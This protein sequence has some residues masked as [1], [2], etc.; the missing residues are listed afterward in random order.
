MTSS[1]DSKVIL[2]CRACHHA[3]AFDAS[4][5]SP[6]NPW[7]C[8]NCN[9][10][11]DDIA[12]ALGVRLGGAGHTGNTGSF[13]AMEDDEDAFNADNPTAGF[14]PSHTERIA[15]VKRRPPPSA[16]LSGG[17]AADDDPWGNIPSQLSDA[18]SGGTD[19][20]NKPEFTEVIDIPKDFDPQAFLKLQQ[21]GNVG[22]NGTDALPV[23]TPGAP[24]A[25]GQ[26]R[27]FNPDAPPTNAPGNG[28]SGA[29]PPG[30]LPP[31]VQFRKLD[32]AELMRQ[33]Q[34][35]QAAAAAPA[36]PAPP[37]EASNKGAALGVGCLIAALVL[38]VI[39]AIAVTAYIVFVPVN[40]G[41]DAP[42]G[43]SSRATPTRTASVRPPLNDRLLAASTSSPSLALVALHLPDQPADGEVAL[44]TPER[45]WYDGRVLAEVLDHRVEPAA[46]PRPNSPWLPGLAARLEHNYRAV[47]DADPLDEALT[48]RWFIL[49]VGRDAPCSAAYETLYTAWERGARLQLASVNPNNPGTFL[50]TEIQPFNWPSPSIHGA[51]ANLPPRVATSGATTGRNHLS[52]SIHSEGF[53]LSVPGRS[54]PIELPR[55][56]RYPLRSLSQ[57]V[58]QHRELD[59][60]I[61]AIHIHARPDTPMY[62]LLRAIGAMTPALPGLPQIAEVRL[63]PP[64]A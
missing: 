40:G 17:A 61:E 8:S 29:P 35:K 59:R 38:A 49:L 45:L 18:R 3:Y 25:P 10:P 55:D 5:V 64:Y 22:P 31:T 28:A 23:I 48:A 41:D 44:I 52:L 62:T 46:H 27:T 26:A 60:T 32:K 7:P 13:E 34:A 47:T 15:P 4:S 43:E 11:L 51:P 63:A 14:M 37:K 19:Q 56:P 54:V 1:A 21:Q 42:K 53:S 24:V 50:A 36:A 9:Q 6:D 16:F 2:F 39:G 33:R 12:R 20:F 30:G 58:A 57:L